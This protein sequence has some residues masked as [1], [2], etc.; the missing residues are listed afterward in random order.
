[1]RAKPMA[2]FIRPWCLL[3]G[4]SAQAI[5]ECID[6]EFKSAGNPKVLTNFCK[7]L[8]LTYYSHKTFLQNSWNFF[9]LQLVKSI[10]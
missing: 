6:Y 1:M 3:G 5:K 2:Y 9:A 4:Y 10:E 7:L 8:S